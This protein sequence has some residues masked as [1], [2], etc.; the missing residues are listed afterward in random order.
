MYNV[1]SP[2]YEST[3]DNVSM[4]LVI[5]EEVIGTILIQINCNAAEMTLEKSKNGITD[6]VTVLYILC[7]YIIIHR[8]KIFSS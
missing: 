7:K 8:A 3:H 6:I 2:A 1:R 4:F 5:L